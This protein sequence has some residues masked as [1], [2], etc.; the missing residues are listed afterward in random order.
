MKR[1]VDMLKGTID[2]QSEKEKG[3]RFTVRLPISVA[4]TVMEENHRA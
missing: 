1:I 4:N 2:L 3:S